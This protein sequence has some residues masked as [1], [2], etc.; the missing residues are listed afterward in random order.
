MEKLI[1]SGTGKCDQAVNMTP[2][3]S[4]MLVKHSHR[5]PLFPL[6]TCVDATLV[7]AILAG[8][9]LSAPATTTGTHGN[10]PV[11]SISVLLP[12]PCLGSCSSSVSNEIS[13]LCIP[14]SQAVAGQKWSLP[15]LWGLMMSPTVLPCMK[16]EHCQHHLDPMSLPRTLLS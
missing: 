3:T 5:K 6:L 9:R 2:S 12:L 16:G 1:F 13:C 15:P 14:C 8:T 7:S 10:M 11:F 4:H